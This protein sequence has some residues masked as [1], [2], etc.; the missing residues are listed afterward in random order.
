M[1]DGPRAT[2]TLD[3]DVERLCALYDRL[4]ADNA[5][6]LDEAAAAELAALAQI[7]DLDAARPHAEVWQDVR[8]VITRQSPRDADDT[9]A[10]MAGEPLTLMLVE[11][12]PDMAADLTE[13]LVAAGHDVV[14]PF[15]NAAAA[16]VAAGLHAIDL[17]LLD[18]NLS[19]ETTGVELARSLKSRWGL[20]SVFL[21]GDVTAAARSADVAEALI[22]KPYTAREVLAV[23]T[24][25]AGRDAERNSPAS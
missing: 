23:A 1:F 22:T 5:D 9:A 17:A 24:R 2:E 7:F 10:P 18:I 13:A 15:H 11:D 12:D 16:E 25:V 6:P 8:A 3:Q 4:L 21:S 19:G 20:R 14:G